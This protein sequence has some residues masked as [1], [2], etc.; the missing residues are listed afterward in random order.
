M[1]RSLQAGIPPVSIEQV[2]KTDPLIPDS[3]QGKHKGHVGT[4]MADGLRALGRQ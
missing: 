3:D 1:N 2:S 4:G